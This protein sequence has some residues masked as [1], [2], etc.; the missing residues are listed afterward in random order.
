MKKK[1]KVK[2]KL[3]LGFFFL[4]YFDP[5]TFHHLKNGEQKKNLYT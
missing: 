1:E 4:Y 2:L 3:Y 5:I